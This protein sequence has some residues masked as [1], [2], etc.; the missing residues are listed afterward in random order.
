[1][2]IGPS[3]K[4]LQDEL[5]HIGLSP[6]NNVVDVTNFVLME[7]GQP[8]HAFDLKKLAGPEIHARR[9]NPG[10]TFV[11]LNDETYSLEADHL[12]IA[13]AE[14][15]VALAGV[16]GG[17]NS[18]VTDQTTDLLV[19]CAYFNPSR[20]RKASSANNL[21]TDSSF[22]FE[23]GVDPTNL[24]KV[25][26]RCVGLIVDLSG[27]RGDQRNHRSEERGA[28]SQTTDDHPPYRTGQHK[29]RVFD[30]EWNSDRSAN[31]I[32]VRGRGERQRNSFGDGPRIPARPRKRN[33]FGGGSGAS[34][35][36]RLHP[37]PS[38]R[39]RHWRWR[40]TRHL[41]L[42]TCDPD[43]PDRP[44]LDRNE[45]VQFSPPPIMRTNSDCQEDHPL[46]HGVAIQNPITADTTM[47]RTNLIA[48][49][50]TNL[51]RNVNYGERDVRIFE[52]GRV[53]L[54]DFENLLDCERDVI[55]LAWLGT[56]ETHW[57]SPDRPYDFFDAKGTGEALLNELGISNYRLEKETRDFF[58]PGQTAKWVAPDGRAF[59]IVGRIHPNVT[60]NFD[61]PSDPIVVEFDIET[62][63]SLIDFESVQVEPPSPFP[64]IRR[65][66]SLTVPVETSADNL[67]D[68]IS[69]S[70][71]PYLEAVNLFDRYLGEQ[72]GEGNQSLGFRVTYRSDEKTLTDEEI[73]P[74]HQDLL[75]SLNDRLGA[76]QRGM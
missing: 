26:D 40:D 47:L 57:S 67:L 59:G 23:R 53:Y 7:C 17:A 37:L 11:G 22:R 61:L 38:P 14:K 13:D 15:P 54:K 25:I 50:L 44:G 6:I 41:R 56:S 60:E 21:S 32:G 3:P 5:R 27:G 63:A 69:Q 75:K 66:L 18:E 58:H 33:R 43:L 64:A 74:I 28:P 9:A 49:L 39:F 51:S 1:M 12:V 46:R 45:V 76:T 8:L 71:T 48:N 2:K 70:E 62:L 42:G 35:W 55:G 4:W 34:V 10:E 52:T 19:E 36:L 73:K 16:M 72:I 20:V 24:E 65:D 31:S 30:S 68:L 29:N